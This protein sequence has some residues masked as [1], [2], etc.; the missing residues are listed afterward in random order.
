VVDVSSPA[1][2][3]EVGFWDTPGYANDVAV[4]GGYAYVADY[5][6][7]LRVV[8]V[9]TPSS[10]ME[11]GFYDTPRWAE[12]VAVAGGYAYV[13]AG[14]EVGLRVVDVST[15]ANPTEAG[16]YDMPGWAW[17]VAAVRNIAYVADQ[18]GGVVILRY[19]LPSITGRALDG[20]G[21]PIEGVQIA[22]GAEYSATTDASG[23]YTITDVLPDTYTLIP[24][25]V[26]YFWSPASRTVTVP[27][28]ATGQD[29]TA[30]NIQKQVTASSRR[31]TVGLNDTLTYTVH[32]IYPDD[33]SLVLYDRVPTYTTYISGSL[34][35]PTG[36]IYDPDIDAISG[37]LSLTA[38]DLETVTFAARVEI[39]GTVGFGPLI[40]NRAC[41]YPVGE[42]LAECEWS[43]EVRSYTYVWPIYL[44]LVLR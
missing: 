43:N 31:G 1:N 39:M 11:V 41:V 30:R 25:T 5:D 19:Q 40:V 22:A 10:P 36:V 16:F 8:D 18:S 29:F 20:S 21:N 35:A 38:G 15:P 13:A 26:G 44:P 34:S 24:T 2:P 6:G 17:S 32:L 7:G 4:A 33:R 14:F 9:S 3:T 23:Q 37:T 12:D 27:P 28:D 42:G